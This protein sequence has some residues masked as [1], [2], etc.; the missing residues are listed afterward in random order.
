M[1]TPEE[2]KQE[3]LNEDTA[4]AVQNSGG[5]NFLYAEYIH[6]VLQHVVNSDDTV[7][8]RFQPN[9]RVDMQQEAWRQAICVVLAY[10]KRFKMDESIQTM[11]TEFPDTPSKSGFAKKAD[12]EMFFTDIA[13]VISQVKSTSFER[14]VKLFADEAGLDPLLQTTRKE[15]KHKHHD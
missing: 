9:V 12:L 6:K 11:R 3:K 8:E 1:A 14:R 2:A 7:V 15:R 4:A 13:D 5:V 10:L